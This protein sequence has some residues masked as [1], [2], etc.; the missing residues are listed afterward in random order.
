[1][2]TMFLPSYK[3]ERPGK[4][5]ISFISQ[6]GAVG[7]VVLDWMAM[8]GYKLSKFISY[9]NATDIDEKDLI[10]YL[11]SDPKTKA[12]CIYIE[13]VKD[14]RKFYEL[15]KNHAK[16][17][18]II[19]LKGGITEQG[20]SAVSSHT[21][22]LA[23]SKEVYETAFRQAGMVQAYDVEQVFDYARVLSTQPRPKGKRV[24]VITDGGGFG[25]ISTDW[26]IRNGMELAR[27]GKKTLDGLKR[28][29]SEYT[30][31]KNP[32]DLTGAATTDDY[33]TALNA[34]ITDK[35]VDMILLI[36]LFQVPLLT[37]DVV[38]VI[39]EANKRKKKPMIVVAAGGRY[40]EVLKKSLEDAG[41]PTFSSPAKASEALRALYDYS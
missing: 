27:M 39:V 17:K 1:V 12:I 35:N 23:G 16:R 22:S 26:L 5:G 2:D 33:R 8:M 38:D 11:A 41:I 13:G 7:S 3:L 40:S 24:Q 36:V 19:I 31:V 20:S 30:I 14:G 25:I 32:L 9:G 37:P 18:P 28:E 6:S 21:G 29:F 34:A 4:G 15:A 10:E